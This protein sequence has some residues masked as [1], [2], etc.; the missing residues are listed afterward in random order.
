MRVTCP[1]RVGD[2]RFDFEADTIG[3]SG[4]TCPMLL[5]NRS[6]I[7]MRMSCHH[8]F[9]ENGDGL[10]CLPGSNGKTTGVRLLLTD[11]GHY[12]LP[13]TP[14]EGK[15]HGDRH[16]QK[17]AQRLAR[18]RAHFAGLTRANPDQEV[19]TTT[20]SFEELESELAF[21]PADLEGC[22]VGSAPEAEAPGLQ[23]PTLDAPPGLEQ[24]DDGVE[25]FPPCVCASCSARQNEKTIVPCTSCSRPVCKKC[26]NIWVVQAMP[27]QRRRRGERDGHGY[28]HQQ[29]GQRSLDRQVS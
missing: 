8:G 15:H 17:D 28:L 27:Q 23:A 7:R 3:Q 20:E 21:P 26:R 13:L 6:A 11:S 10:L 1:I 16:V 5:S 19:L 18:Q 14:L 29:V 12:I 24:H 9:Y 2:E 25:G 22:T 4:D